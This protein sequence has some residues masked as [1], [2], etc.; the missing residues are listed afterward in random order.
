MKKNLNKTYTTDGKV[1]IF[2]SEDDINTKLGKIIGK[3]FKEY[4][5]KWDLANKMELVTDFPL[6]L[7]LDMDQLNHLLNNHL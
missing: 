1:K 2:S 5:K 6:F 7:H 3:K 4:R